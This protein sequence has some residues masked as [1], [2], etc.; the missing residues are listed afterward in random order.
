MGI[1]SK[2]KKHSLSTIFRILLLKIFYIQIMK[3]HY[4]KMEINIDFLRQKLSNF[5]LKVKE[6]KYEDFL[7]GDKDAF[8]GKKMEVLKKRFTDPTYKGY[9]II[10]NG[11][12]IYSAWISLEK[13]G[14]P[15]ISNIKL[16]QNEGYLEDDYTHPL[17]RGKGIHGKMILY[18]QEKLF[19]LG[20]SVCLVTVLDGN[21]HAL[22]SQLKLGAR[23]LGY[24]YAGM[25][26]G[27]PFVTLNKNKY[28]CK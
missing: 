2:F 17:H 1:I 18:R 7:L 26:F 9:G 16:L 23:N 14:L 11:V 5:D 4:L 15:V 13:L 3:I 28:D 21:V 10:E 8:L 25:I 6:L 24:F 19:E 27:I 12:L 20:K 22:N